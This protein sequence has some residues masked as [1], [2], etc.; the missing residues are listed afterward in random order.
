MYWIQP[1]QPVI[2]F[3]YAMLVITG[4]AVILIIFIGERHL[5]ISKM[6]LNLELADRFGNI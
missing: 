4:V 3:I 6:P 1:Y 5:K 2:K